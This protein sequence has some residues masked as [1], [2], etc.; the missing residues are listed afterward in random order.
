MPAFEVHNLRQPYSMIRYYIPQHVYVAF[1]E[2]AAVFLDLRS[3]R[4]SMLLGA[5]A[6]A[7]KDLVVAN[8]SGTRVINL[9]KLPG[10]TFLLENEVLTDLLQ[11]T[12]LTTSEMDAESPLG[13][14]VQLP[15]ANLIESSAS[16][17]PE[18]SLLDACR[19]VTSCTTSHFMLKFFNIE[20]TVRSVER[21]KPADEIDSPTRAIELR[22]LVQIYHTLRPLFPRNYLCLFDSLSLLQFLARYGFR[23]TWVFAV[24]LDPWSAH[25]WLQYGTAVLNEDAD[26][27]RNY[28]P[29]LAV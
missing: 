13:A 17:S 21:L 16:D 28:L 4:Y 26:Q 20:K 12:L 22:R 23:P 1:A 3:D 25:C 9:G 24:R 7:F 11:N 10:S 14:G 6:R 8:G 18:I 2:D 5:K 29:I 27:A 19:F 15:E